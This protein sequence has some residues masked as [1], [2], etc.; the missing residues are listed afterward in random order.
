MSLHNV[1]KISKLMFSD[2]LNLTT[3]S[4]RIKMKIQ[5]RFCPESVH[6]NFL[7]FFGQI[8][9]IK[10][11]ITSLMCQLHF[12]CHQKPSMMLRAVPSTRIVCTINN[13]IRKNKNTDHCKST[14]S[15]L[16]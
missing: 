4:L 10:K 3:I 8:P 2:N 12:I 16:Q 7:N 6:R 5:N 11:K 1:L 15:S 13:L 14:Q 9:N